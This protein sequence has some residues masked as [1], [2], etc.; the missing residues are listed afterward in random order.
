MAPQMKKMF[1]INMFYRIITD[2]NK[3]NRRHSRWSKSR[4][5]NPPNQTEIEVYPK[6]GIQIS[7]LTQMRQKK[8][9]NQNLVR[10]LSIHPL[11]MNTIFSLVDLPLLYSLFQHSRCA[12]NEKEP[13]GKACP[14]A[15]QAAKHSK[16]GRRNA[17]T[18]HNC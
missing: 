18:R 3:S 12:K 4:K 7:K 9:A 10:G 11:R 13:V 15:H 16:D 5:R 14:P 2:K 1:R 17:K 6:N 8:C